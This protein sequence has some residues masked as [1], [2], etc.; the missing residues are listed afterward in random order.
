MVLSPSRAASKPESVSGERKWTE[1][2]IRIGNYQFDG[3][4][5]STAGLEDKSG[6]YAILDQRQDGFHV[7]DIGESHGVKSRVETHDRQECWK[8]RSAGTLT[9]A[10][11]YTPGQQQSGR[12][13][14]EQELR[15]QF[16]PPCGT[17]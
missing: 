12:M 9:V 14:I 13:A 6:V 2:S 4:F 7:L 16:N 1:M 15:G 3:P 5:N 8:R 11:H 10:A 17:N